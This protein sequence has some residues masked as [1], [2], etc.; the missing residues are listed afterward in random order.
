MFLK[1]MQLAGCLIVFQLMVI[2]VSSQNIDI[3]ILKSINPQYP[4]SGYW[5]GVSK[6]YILVTGT[7][8]IGELAYGLLAH[9][10]KVQKN[11][12]ET[13]IGIGINIV[14]TTGMKATFNRTRPSDKYP[15]DVFVLT[16]SNGHSFPSGHTSLAFATATSFA[17]Q[18]K[19]WYVVVPAYLWAGSVGYSRMYLGKH[20]PTDVLAGAVVGTGSSLLSHWISKKIFKPKKQ[21]S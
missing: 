7:A 5:K 19:K 6:S 12:C 2:N 21:R 3:D 17:I 18:Y 14:V 1:K 20:Y 10:E 16:T 4:Q 13:L 11:A 8:T 15:N 9:D